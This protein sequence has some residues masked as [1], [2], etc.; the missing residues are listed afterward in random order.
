MA[1]NGPDCSTCWKR[2]Q[3]AGAQDGT[4]CP[5]WQSHEPQPRG[6]GWAEQWSRGDDE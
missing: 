5:A 4:F 3:C 6:D 2:G 1:D